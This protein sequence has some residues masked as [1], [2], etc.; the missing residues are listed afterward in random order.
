MKQE[1]LAIAAVPVQEWGD[2]YDREEA[3]KRG[4]VFPELDL[5]CF[6]VDGEDGMEGCVSGRTEE[7]GSREERMRE[8]QEAGFYADDLKLYLDTHP[9][10]EKAHALF[11]GA[12]Q[13]KRELMREFARELYPLTPDCMAELYAEHPEQRGWLWQKG[14]PPW[15]G[16]CR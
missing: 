11:R 13:R 9:E 8:I 12:I 10:E 6:A 1:K 5:P 14:L 4:T 3:L 15:E 7:G 2:V 16:G